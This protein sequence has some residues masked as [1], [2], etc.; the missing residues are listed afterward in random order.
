[1]TMR[2]LWVLAGLLL[3]G[4]SST[5]FAEV[6]KAAGTDPTT[7]CITGVYSGAMLG[8]YRTNIQNGEVQCNGNGLAIKSSNMAIPA[9]IQLQQP[10]T[11]T[12]P[13]K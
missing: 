2:W 9:T 7:V 8:Y 13:P 11:V 4:C 10:V 1:M 3:A 6:I 12:P 5:N